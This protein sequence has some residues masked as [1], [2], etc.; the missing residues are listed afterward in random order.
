[1]IVIL[2]AL[3]MAL[4]TTNSYAQYN[5]ECWA[6]DYYNVFKISS[7]GQASQFSGFSQP[8][9]LSIN[10]K[11]GS[12]WIADTDAVV[13]K[14]LSA[15]GKEI[16]TIGMDILV[17]NPSSVS[18]DPRDGSCWVGVIDTVF[19][20]SADGKQLAKIGGF[21]E[22]I[23]SVNPQNGDCW[24]AD[25]SNARVVRLSA[26]GGQ[27]NSME[28]PGVTQPKSISVNP[29]DGNCWVLDAFTHKLV[30]LSSDGKI[31]LSVDVIAAENAI[32]STYVCASSDGGCWVSVM[33]DMMN[34]QVLKFSA[35]GKKVLSVDG[36]SMPSG[37]AADPKDGGCWV[38]DSNAGRIVKLSAGG[39][40]VANIEGFTQPKV[41]MVAHSV[42]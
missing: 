34:D 39:Q 35:D 11:D 25:S 1:M 29:T 7:S 23:L 17:N 30:K 5:G 15:T 32:M 3:I 10:P 4:F 24:V 6:A 28:L 9:S 20:F 13:V 38:A 12:C 41:V 18:V 31:L 26:A 16:L 27:L 36:F 33:I 42:K 14:K 40:A 21:N 19:K 37:L 22:P 8:L 2:S